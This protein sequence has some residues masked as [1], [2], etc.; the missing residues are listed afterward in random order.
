MNPFNYCLYL[1]TDENACNGRDL[2]TIIEEAVKG[3]VDIVQIREKKLSQNDFLKKTLRLKEMLDRYNIP[4]IVNDSLVVA[5]A[6]KTAGIH[7]GNSDYSPE[8]VRQLWSKCGILGYSIEF[9]NQIQSLQA[10]YSD[11]LAL[12]PVFST[13]TKTDTIVEWGL[14]GI[15]HVRTLTSKPL[16]AI[17][18]INHNNASE[19]V[20]AGADCLAIVSAICSA[21]KPGI[22]AEKLRNIIEKHKPYRNATV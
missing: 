3:G 6:G 1:V 9:E 11:Y 19:V 10:N 7:V 14:E 16:V 5:L 20:D 18:N 22:A 15:R 12:S 4:L 17:G 21:E 13:T 8:V 2:F